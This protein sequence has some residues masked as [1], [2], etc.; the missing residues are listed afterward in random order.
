MEVRIGIKENGRDLSFE[1]SLSAKELTEK[2]SEAISTGAPMLE[3]S[4]DKGKTIL[5]ATAS[6][7]Y[8]EIGADQGRRVGFIA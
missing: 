1:S 8:V 6:I 5:I 7:A 2:I 4:D 3:L